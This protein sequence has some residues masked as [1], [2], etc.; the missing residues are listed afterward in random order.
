VVAEIRE[1]LEAATP[2]PIPDGNEFSGYIL[3]EAWAFLHML[4]DPEQTEWLTSER[5]VRWLPS[6]AFALHDR[7]PYLVRR[8]A[9]VDAPATIA[10]MLDA[11]ERE[12]R[13]GLRFA[14]RAREIPLEWWTNPTIVDRVV[15]WAKNDSFSVEARVD[16]ER[17]K[18]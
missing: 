12:L 4:E 6:A 16:L 14:V 18:E 5:V 8:C 15:G 13:S 11:G 2:T 9:A 10:I 1:G 3:C 7:I 17:L